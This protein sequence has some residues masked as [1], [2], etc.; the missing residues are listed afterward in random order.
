MKVDFYNVFSMNVNL[1]ELDVFPQ[2][3]G[4]NPNLT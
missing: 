3:V 1:I 4:L 2:K